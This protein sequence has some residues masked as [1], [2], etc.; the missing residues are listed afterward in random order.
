MRWCV[1]FSALSKLAFGIPHSVPRSTT[2]LTPSRNCLFHERMLF[3]PL[4]QAPLLTQ[5][6]CLSMHRRTRALRQSKTDLPSF[7]HTPAPGPPN[8][9]PGLA[10]GLTPPLCM[11]VG[12][13]SFSPLQACTRF[14]ALR[15]C[16]HVSCD[17]GIAEGFKRPNQFFLL[18]VP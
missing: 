11:C 3:P 14:L 7:V 12:L 4:H 18:T 13:L 15:R 9:F 5:A 16:P 1:K 2:M 10:L 6:P 17:Q 8:P